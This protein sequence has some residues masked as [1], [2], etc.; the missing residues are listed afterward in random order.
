LEQLQLCVP[1]K[2]PVT[3]NTPVAL[4]NTQD[5]QLSDRTAQSAF[6]PV[7]AWERDDDELPAMKNRKSW[8]DEV[9][10]TTWAIESESDSRGWSTES[11]SRSG[12]LNGAPPFCF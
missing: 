2:K 1:S 5:S 11:C 3:A 9:E 4:E 7:G 8:L 12:A 6:V 10:E